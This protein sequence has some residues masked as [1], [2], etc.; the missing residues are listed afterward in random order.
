MQTLAEFYENWV[1]VINQQSREIGVQV[2]A[3]QD[4][5]RFL[6]LEPQFRSEVD[7]LC[8]SY[9]KSLPSMPDIQGNLE[10]GYLLHIRMREGA[11]FAQFLL[12][13]GFGGL[14]R[15]AEDWLEFLLI[16]SWSEILVHKWRHDF[17]E[18]YRNRGTSTQ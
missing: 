6:S 9:L 16:D 11:D 1:P 18:F 17:A 14:Q 15:D 13:S 3:G 12:Q 7:Y 8:L 5:S 10:A 2:E 4:M